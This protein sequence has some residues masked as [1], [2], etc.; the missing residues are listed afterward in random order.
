MTPAS[1]AFVELAREHLAAGRPLVLRA[2]GHSMWPAVRDGEEV[3][4][5]PLTAAPLAPGAIAL[6]ALGSRL[7]LHRI[8]ATSASGLVTKGDAVPHADPPVAARDLLGHL[9]RRCPPFDR[10]VAAL[11]QRAGPALAFALQRTRVALARS[12]LAARSS[13]P[14]PPA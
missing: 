6:V 1:A 5:L 3:T 10:L 13:S 2:Q 7:V 14:S 8:I 11:S 4:V 12:R 9:P